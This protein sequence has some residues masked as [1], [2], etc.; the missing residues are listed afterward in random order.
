MF[1]AV[2]NT[3]MERLHQAGAHIVRNPF[4]R[5]L[6]K[7]ELHALLPGVIGLI[8]GLE[9][10]TRDVL[11][12]SQLKVIS[13]CGVGLSNVDLQAAADLGIVVRS[14]PD[15]P[16][17]AVAELTVG[18]MLSLLRMVGWM[19]RDLHDG[20][21]NKKIGVQLEGKTVVIIGFG[22]IGQK[23]A[24]LLAPFNA[25]II[26]V[27][28]SRT[29]CGT[30]P[31]LPLHEALRRADIVTAHCSGETCILGEKEFTLLK[32][33]AFVL[34]G[35]RGGVIDEKAL[36]KSLDEGR[37]AGAWLDSFEEE[38]YRGPLTKYPQVIL[39]PHVGSYTQECRTRMELEAVDNLLA[40]LRPA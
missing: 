7:E 14:T 4:K 25:T 24:S 16:T 29:D 21:W 31:I 40:A 20:A 11:E 1:G 13:R 32:P 12:I 30:V 3:P 9:P 37:V 6:T 36:M 26:A 5:K 17:T 8:A 27:D 28:P 35:A 19:D 34:N 22:R 2:D 10:L 39:T 15:A 23:V 33:G 38:P 18:A